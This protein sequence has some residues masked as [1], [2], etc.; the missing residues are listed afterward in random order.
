MQSKE[1]AHDFQDQ[2]ENAFNMKDAVFESVHFMRFSH[3][4]KRHQN[5][6]ILWVWYFPQNKKLRCILLRRNMKREFAKLA[7]ASTYIINRLDKN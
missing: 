3:F 4:T 2:H 6:D 7:G 5:R 1:I